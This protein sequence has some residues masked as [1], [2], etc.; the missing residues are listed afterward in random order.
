VKTRDAPPEW[1]EEEILAPGTSG[2]IA[3]IG[4]GVAEAKKFSKFLHG[5]AATAS[6]RL[7]ATVIRELPHWWGLAE[8]A[9]PSDDA[10]DEHDH[11]SAFVSAT[12]EAPEVG[13]VGDECVV[14]VESP[15]AAGTLPAGK[16]STFFG[17]KTAAFFRRLG[18]TRDPGALRGSRRDRPSILGLSCFSSARTR[19][20][21]PSRKREDASFAAR[22]FAPI[23]VEPKTFFA[24]ER[25]LLQWLSMAV[26]VLFTSLALLT[27][28]GPGAANPGTDPGGIGVGGGF[29]VDGVRPEGARASSA[30]AT[31]PKPPASA[32][33]A[34]G[35]AL[36]PV[37]VALMA[38]ALWTYLW[39]ASRIAR[40]EPSARYDDRWGPVA[41]VATLIV[42]SVAAV[43]VAATSRRWGA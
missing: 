26:L 37:A 31:S 24:N 5:T 3:R 8:T 42:A 35:A 27:L 17:R 15:E 4:S 36:A 25:T 38:Y 28:D 2:S 23:K 34:S 39:R 33:A 20:R 11:A 21:P 12:A 14:F 29:G 41:L 1:I 19:M 10:H 9:F 18:A 13:G 32:A 43:A 22:R 6:P 7:R 30:G 16:P 40:R